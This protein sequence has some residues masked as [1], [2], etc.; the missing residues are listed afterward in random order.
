M[1][2]SPI[3]RDVQDR[4][5]MSRGLFVTYRAYLE[6]PFGG[7][8][9]CTHEYIDVIGAA[10]IALTFCVFDGDKR[11]STRILRRLNSSAYFRPAEPGI[12]KVIARLAIETQPEFVFLNQV[13]LAFL[14]RQIRKSLPH[15]C[16][17]VLLSHGL[18]STDLLHS[19]RARRRLPLSGRV[20][21]TPIFALGSDLLEESGARGDVDIV[22]A[23]SPFDV[24]LEHWIGMKHVG[25]LPRVVRSSPLDWRPF[26][27]RIGY[28]GTLDHAP[29]LEGLVTILSQILAQPTENVRIR[30]VGGPPEI[31]R[32]LAQSYPIIDYLGSTDDSTLAREAA[33]W[34]AVANPI[35]CYPRG[36]STKLATAVGWHIPVVTTTMGHRG[37]EWRQG[38]PVI[39]DDPKEFAEEC[40]RLLNFDAASEARR[41]VAEMA[42]SSPTIDENASRLRALI[43]G[44]SENTSC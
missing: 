3:E 30:V 23:L 37:Y 35:F 36:C 7:V 25:W 43:N 6:R 41:R 40:L 21:P 34:S 33:T 22:C 27:N 8:Q 17:I 2:C 14:A 20:R 42:R 44:H 28:I 13:N 16:K 1:K 24:H 4:I 29:N 15:G 18:S 26:G 5:G 32:W 19:I 39:A 12:I 38:G 9:V 31:G 11:F 10:G